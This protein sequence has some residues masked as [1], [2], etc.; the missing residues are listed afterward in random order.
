MSTLPQ[1]QDGDSCPLGRARGGGAVEKE[2]V[3]RGWGERTGAEDG[4]EDGGE[5]PARHTLE[6]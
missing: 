5:I 6:T 4:G 3:W 2:K 1:K